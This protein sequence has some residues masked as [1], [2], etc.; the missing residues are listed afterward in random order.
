MSCTHQIWDWNTAFWYVFS[1]ERY[2]TWP[3]QAFSCFLFLFLFRPPYSKFSR[4]TLALTPDS[5]VLTL[6]H[7]AN[8]QQMTFLFI[9]LYLYFRENKTWHFMWMVCQ[10]KIQ[11]IICYRY[12]WRFRVQICKSTSQ[13]IGRSKN[14]KISAN[15]VDPNQTDKAYCDIWFGYI[16]FVQACMSQYLG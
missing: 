3:T 11:N 16:Q 15:S 1:S 13:L 9:S 14:N 8:L 5:L 4:K 6:K 10:A 7:Q 2:F 12:D